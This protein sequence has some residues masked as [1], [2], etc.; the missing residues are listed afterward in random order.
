MSARLFALVLSGTLALAPASSIASDDIDLDLAS[1][2]LSEQAAKIRSDLADRETY[3]EIGAAD[4]TAVLNL[5]EQMEL[6]LGAT[7]SVE[8]LTDAQKVELFNAQERINTILT[9]AREDSRQVCER[10]QVTG[11]HR[12]QVTC[13]TVAERRRQRESSQQELEHRRRMT[14]ANR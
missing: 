4:R 11:S 8:A 1:R 14:P 6:E 9:G 7:G 3:V 13:T 5:L 10:R 2:P 12:K